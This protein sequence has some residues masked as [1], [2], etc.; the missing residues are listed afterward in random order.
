MT[1]DPWTFKQKV[2]NNYVSL[3]NDFFKVWWPF[4]VTWWALCESLLMFMDISSSS[5]LRILR[6][7]IV[8]VNTKRKKKIVQRIVQTN[9]VLIY[10]CKKFHVK[11]EVVAMQMMKKTQVNLLGEALHTFE[12]LLHFIWFYLLLVIRYFSNSKIRRL[13]MINHKW[14]G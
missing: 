3:C 14:M 13:T 10:S 12:P 2:K 1:F 8:H 6:A 11:R 5:S 4:V 7:L 9:W